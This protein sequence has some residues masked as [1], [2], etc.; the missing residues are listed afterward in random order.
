MK[1]KT[2]QRQKGRLYNARKA[3]NPMQWCGSKE[4]AVTGKKD[5]MGQT[6]GQFERLRCEQ[7]AQG[8]PQK[9]R[10]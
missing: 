8:V 3:G 1:E 5:R 9:K 4:T 10:T 2:N 7:I 6:E